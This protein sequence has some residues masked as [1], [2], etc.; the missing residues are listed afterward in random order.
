[1]LT[2]EISK[3]K[4]DDLSAPVVKS[5]KDLFKQIE[6]AALKNTDLDY[7]PLVIELNGTI[8]RLKTDVNI[9][10]ANNKGELKA[11]RRSRNLKSSKRL[12]LTMNLPAQR[13][14]LHQ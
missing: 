7:A 2:S 12:S 13:L 5:L 14:N 4:T 8:R 1:M 10:L 11:L 9:R 6:V 3:V